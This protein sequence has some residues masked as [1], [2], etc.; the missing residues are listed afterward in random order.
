MPH[1]ISGNVLTTKQNAKIN[2]FKK[3]GVP[4]KRY[5]TLATNFLNRFNRFR[6]LANGNRDDALRAMESEG[7]VNGVL[8]DHPVITRLVN[9]RI[10]ENRIGL[11]PNA[12]ENA[13]YYMMNVIKADP[14]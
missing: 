7:I 3:N 8:R 11:N 10:P 5:E 4:T 6:S 12:T 2:I 1:T 14:K 9:S 13:I